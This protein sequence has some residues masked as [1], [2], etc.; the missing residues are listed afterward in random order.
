MKTKS[1]ELS[2]LR[3]VLAN[4]IS[5]FAE[6][7]ASTERCDNSGHA[8]LHKAILEMHDDFPKWLQQR[9]EFLE[10]TDIKSV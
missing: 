7:L 10:H 8:D 9:I 4:E 1:S 6:Y 5:A 3:G 2:V